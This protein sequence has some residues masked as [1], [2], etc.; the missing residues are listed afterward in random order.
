MLKYYDWPELIACSLVCKDWHQYIMQHVNIKEKI[1]DFMLKK[2]KIYKFDQNLYLKYINITGF[3]DP[4]PI[5]FNKK[6]RKI[7]YHLDRKPLESVE[8]LLIRC[9]NFVKQA[10]IFKIERI[11]GQP[12]A[13]C[14]R[15]LKIKKSPRPKSWTKKIKN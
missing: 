9:L 12:M 10:N 1:I 8:K 6:R 15:I 4:P 13:R 5:E 11:L 7:S 2:P 3:F 14:I